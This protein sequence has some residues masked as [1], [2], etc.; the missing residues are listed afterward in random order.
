MVD[1]QHARVTPHRRYPSLPQLMVGIAVI[2]FSTAG[3]A[4][5]MGWRSSTDHPD[6]AIAPP[7]SAANATNAAKAVALAAPAVQKRARAKAKAKARALGKCA[8]CGLI[9]SIGDINE[10]PD[11]SGAGATDASSAGD[12]ITQSLD[13]TAPSEMVVRMADGSRRVIS[14]ANPALW[15]L[16][17]RVVIIAGSIPPQR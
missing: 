4:A 11:D 1:A 14:N 17:E 7:V 6:R 5:I 15:R 8:E 16:G 13:S 12:R 3:I 2:L 9:E 10:R